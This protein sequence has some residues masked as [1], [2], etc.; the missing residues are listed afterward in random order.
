MRLVRWPVRDWSHGK[1]LGAVVYMSILYSL[2]MVGVSLFRSL[3]SLSLPGKWCVCVWRVWLILLGNPWQRFLI[4]Q[5]YIYLVFLPLSSHPS[6]HPSLLVR[7]MYYISELIYSLTQYIDDE[8][9]FL[10]ILLLLLM[11]SSFLS[12]RVSLSSSSS[13]YTITF[14][15]TFIVV[16]ADK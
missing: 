7:F 16:S 6:I 4:H 13:L 5:A 15:S 10:L 8:K 3:P 2:L 11:S 9:S 12:R 14:I 1:Q